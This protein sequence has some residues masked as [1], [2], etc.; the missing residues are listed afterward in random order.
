MVW[1]WKASATAPLR[2]QFSALFAA[3]PVDRIS[4]RYG[5]EG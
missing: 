5:L 3:T 1:G 2:F 4:K